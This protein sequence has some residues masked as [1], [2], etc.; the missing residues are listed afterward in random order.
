MQEEFSC[1]V[2]QRIGQSC[3]YRVYV[4]RCGDT[5]NRVP[6]EPVEVHVPGMIASYPAFPIPIF[7]TACDKNLGGWKCWVRGYS[8]ALSLLVGYI[9]TAC[10]YIVY[11]EGKA[12]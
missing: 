4:V 9:N 7:H 2:M 6:S 10:P 8:C 12:S 11:V 3:T 5:Q 1:Q